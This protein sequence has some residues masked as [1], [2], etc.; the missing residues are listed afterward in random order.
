V[1]D[2]EI[3]GSYQGGEGVGGGR[4]GKGGRVG[5][6]MQGEGREVGVWGGERWRGGGKGDMRAGCGV[7]S[8]L[9]GL[10]GG[11]AES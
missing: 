5:G 9:A 4:R 2:D 3:V 11:W 10:G 1:R 8:A 6:T 7:L